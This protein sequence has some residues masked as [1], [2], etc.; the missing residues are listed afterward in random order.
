MYGQVNFEDFVT[1]TQF[2]PTI[3]IIF[4]SFPYID[5]IKLRTCVCVCVYRSMYKYLT[6]VLVPVNYVKHMFKT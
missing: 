4:V 5:S 3:C 2:S 1:P 6:Q